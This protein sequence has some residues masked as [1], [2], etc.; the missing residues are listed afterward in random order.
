MSITVVRQFEYVHE[1][2]GSS[3]LGAN[4]FFVFRLLCV[5]YFLFLYVCFLPYLY[6]IYTIFLLNDLYYIIVWLHKHSIKILNDSYKV[7][8]YIL[9][10][11]E[12]LSPSD[13][14]ICETCIPL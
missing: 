14:A 7:L 2:L 13:R 9:Y 3:R 5:Y 10:K 4:I 6:L 1:L 11:H 12:Q 8:L